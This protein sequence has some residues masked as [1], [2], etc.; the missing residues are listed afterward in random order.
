MVS[1]D[2]PGAEALGAVFE[3]ASPEDARRLLRTRWHI[4]ATT[5]RRVTTER[6]DTFLVSEGASPHPRYVLKIDNPLEDTALT[7]LQV[8]ALEHVA[9]KD[10]DLPVQRVLRTATGTTTAPMESD[11]TGR[12]ARVLSFITGEPVHTAGRLDGHVLTSIGQ[13][14]GRLVTALSDFRHPADTRTDDLLWE[15]RALPRLRP[16]V[17]AF[18]AS[19]QRRAFHRFIDH[20]ESEVLPRLAPLRQQ[21]LHNDFNLTNVLVDAEGV[22]GILDFGDVVRTQVA[23]DLAVTLTYFVLRGDVGTRTEH[24]APGPA[25]RSDPRTP[26]EPGELANLLAGYLKHRDIREEE[27]AVLAELVLVRL[28]ITVLIPLWTA[29]RHPERRGY[30]ERFKDE[31]TATFLHHLN[32]GA[33]ALEADIRTALAHAHVLA[34]SELPR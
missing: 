19:D 10:P 15:M 5:L 29:D 1:I 4:D 25:A 33:A 6:D 11:G 3:P 7:D 14:Q 17:D 12:I 2:I 31:A 27:L 30:L 23:S 13:V 9:R 28:A 22:A 24:R 16:L 34:S 8:K 26:S 20:A 18:I 21:V 32:R